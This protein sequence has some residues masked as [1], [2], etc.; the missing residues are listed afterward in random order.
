MTQTVG[1]ECMQLAGQ[2]ETGGRKCPHKFICKKNSCNKCNKQNKNMLCNAHLKQCLYNSIEVTC[3]QHSSRPPILCYRI[4]WIMF[5]F[6]AYNTP[7]CLLVH[8]DA[9]KIDC[10]FNNL[11]MKCEARSFVYTNC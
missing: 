2:L 3:Q 7:K 5:L 8:D 11:R 9:T 10:Q 6:N 1:E 4:D